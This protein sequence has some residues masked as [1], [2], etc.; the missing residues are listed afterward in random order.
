MALPTNIIS[1]PDGTFTEV[2]KP[3]EVNL[4][5]DE[6]TL[7]ELCLFD[8]EGFTA[9]G[10][11]AFLIWHTNWTKEEIGKLT[12]RDLREVVAQMGAKLQAQSVPFAN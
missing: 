7:D 4:D 1:N 6:M 2:P 10:F 12:V 11:R 3:L 8:S 9:S 5:P